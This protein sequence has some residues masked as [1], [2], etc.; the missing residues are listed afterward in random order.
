MNNEQLTAQVNEL[1]TSNEGL[2]QELVRRAQEHQA[3]HRALEELRSGARPS[4]GLSS[5]KHEAAKR[6][7]RWATSTPERTFAGGDDAAGL[8][9]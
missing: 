3:L 7:D 6:L 1:I 8:R 4:G 5:A 2:K 9:G